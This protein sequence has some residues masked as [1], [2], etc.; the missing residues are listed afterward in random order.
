LASSNR[1]SA[2]VREQRRIG[3][4]LH[5]Q[6]VPGRGGHLG[7]GAQR[8]SGRLQ[9]EAHPA[10]RGVLIEAGDFERG[11]HRT[12]RGRRKQPRSSHFGALRQSTSIALTFRS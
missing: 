11:L 7:V 2:D 6:Q 10:R 9:L 5:A 4:A 1:R 8:R 3:L 12:M